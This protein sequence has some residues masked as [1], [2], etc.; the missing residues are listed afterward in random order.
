MVDISLLV[1]SFGLINSCLKGE[2]LAEEEIVELKNDLLG[3]ANVPLL[4]EFIMIPLLLLLLLPL[5]LLSSAADDTFFIFC[6][7]SPL[8]V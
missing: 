2:P 4:K 3:V 7:Y 1:D 6:S 8:Q 5:P